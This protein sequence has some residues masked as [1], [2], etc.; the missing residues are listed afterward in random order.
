[1]AAGMRDETLSHA[2]TLATA[3]TASARAVAALS[4]VVQALVV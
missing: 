3:N 4:A 2:H 1:M